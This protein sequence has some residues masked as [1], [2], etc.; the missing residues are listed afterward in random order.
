MPNVINSASIDTIGARRREATL[1]ESPIM[2]R[3]AAAMIRINSGKSSVSKLM[4]KSLPPVGQTFL[5]A[6]VFPLS[7]ISPEH[8]HQNHHDP[9]HHRPR[10]ALQI[11]ALR[12][13]LQRKS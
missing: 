6:F 7:S 5:S 9:K 2:N 13:Q 1:F 12:R 4:G 8:H 10:V 11:S 3:A